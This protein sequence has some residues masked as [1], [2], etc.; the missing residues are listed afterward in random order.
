MQ[1]FRC[2]PLAERSLL[3]PHEAAGVVDVSHDVNDPCADVIFV[4]SQGA[5][6]AVAADGG[7]F[8]G[9]SGGAD[10]SEQ[11]AGR[12]GERH[13]FVLFLSLFL[14]FFFFSSFFLILQKDKGLLGTQEIL[15]KVE[16]HDWNQDGYIGKTP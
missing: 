4:F 9:A 10:G 2:A 16:M 13:P 6:G 1:L 15:P 8:E 14:L 5:R 7:P 12:G 3:N 11:G